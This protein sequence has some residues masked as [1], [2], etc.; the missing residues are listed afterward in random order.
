MKEAHGSGNA[1]FGTSALKFN[2]TGDG[3]VA[4]G[5]DALIECIGGSNNTM[6]GSNADFATGGPTDIYNSTALGYHAE[7]TESDQVRLGNNDIQTLFCMGAY[8]S[9]TT[10][11]PNLYVS[12]NGQIMRVYLPQ[13]SLSPLKTAVNSD[14]M[15]IP[16]NSSRKVEFLIENCQPGQVV[17]ISPAMELPDGLVIAY[18]RINAP[19][20]V[21][22]KFTNT[23]DQQIDPEI[24][25][26]IITVLN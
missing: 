25:D 26:Y 19:G 10:E 8:N 1:A 4:I 22:I 5:S 21:E 9:T 13:K 7:V 20:K 6:V 24:M 15:A 17:F 2:A 12:P 16:A 14:L 18:A 3:N 11:P 23:T